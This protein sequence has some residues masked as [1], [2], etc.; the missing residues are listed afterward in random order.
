MGHV[1]VTMR[2]KTTFWWD[3][4]DFVATKEDLVKLKNMLSN[5]DVIEASTKERANTKWKFYKLANGSVFAALL[6]EFPMGH[7][8]QKHWKRGVN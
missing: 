7:K 3:G 8:A 1:D 2:A 5:T 4:Q 6:K